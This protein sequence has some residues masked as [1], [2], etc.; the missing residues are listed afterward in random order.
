MGFLALA[1]WLVALG[2]S[3]RFIR[4]A[5]QQTGATQTTPLLIWFSIFLLVTLQLSTSL[6][7]ILGRSEKLLTTEKKFF[8]QHWVEMIGESLDENSGN[9]PPQTS[10]GTG[11]EVSGEENK[12]GW[13]ENPAAR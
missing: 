8:L 13:I 2:F 4:T 10:R 1:S 12:N 11:R 3:F 6:R 5:L 9:Q 7:P